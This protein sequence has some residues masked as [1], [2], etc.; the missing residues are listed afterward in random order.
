MPRSSSSSSCLKSLLLPAI[1]VLLVA[2]VI[3]VPIRATQ[4]YGPPGP[5]LGLQ[6]TLEYSA[7]LLWYDG[8]LT[9]P[10]NSSGLEQPFHIEA[11]ESVPSIAQR[12]EQ[13][14]LISDAGA[15]RDYL[16]Y[17]GLDMTLQAGDYKLS[18]RLSI[19]DMARELQDATP[20]DVTFVVL[21]G[22]RMEEIAASLPTSGLDLTP[23]QFLAVAQ[24]AP[25]GYDFLDPASSSEGFL[26]PDAYVLPRVTTAQGL[27]DELV[28]NFG[29]HLT[30]ELQEGFTRQGLSVREAV[31]LASIVER[32]AVQKE[33]QAL[34]ASVFLNRLRT[35][36][37]LD[38][39][40][41]VQYALGYNLVQQTWWTNP[42]SAAD[43]QTDSPYN[44]YARAGL[45][46]GPIA[47]PGPDALHA[48]A[49]PAETTFY[50]FRARC[51]GSGL[52]Q[53]AETFEE[54]LNNACP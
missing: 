51:D 2:A 45:P 24:Y 5:S 7:R 8:I 13:A 19:V 22:W 46:P 9:Q 17:K 44:T 54:H 15:F 41:T 11:G 48:V 6:G 23:E 37:K 16:I 1:L 31:I 20:E 18:P 14:S 39:D 30:V 42:L 35:G 25:A 40:P 52:H 26:Y 3:F 49:F 47:N 32:E 27:R 34:I 43:L 38:S 12:L 50:Y 53:F 33:E 10:F 36:I 4:L 29:L 21:P 28:R